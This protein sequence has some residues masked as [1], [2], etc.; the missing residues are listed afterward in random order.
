[1]KRRIGKS[2]K[3]YLFVWLDVITD[4]LIWCVQKILHEFSAVITNTCSS[5]VSV[6][7]ETPEMVALCYVKHFKTSGDAV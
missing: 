2:V 7:T 5:L 3:I 1:M 4:S 6:A